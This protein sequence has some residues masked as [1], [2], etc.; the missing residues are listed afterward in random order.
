MFFSQQQPLPPECFNVFV[1]ALINKEQACKYLME[2][3]VFYSKKSLMVKV[4]EVRVHVLRQVHFGHS[5]FKRHDNFGLIERG[6]LKNLLQ[7]QAETS[8]RT[9]RRWKEVC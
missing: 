6:Q 4:A 9:E 7:G 2:K 5:I 8:R 3:G 1:K